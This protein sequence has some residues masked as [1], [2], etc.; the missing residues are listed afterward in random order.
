MIV[1]AGCAGLAAAAELRRAGVEDVSVLEARPR[2]GGRIHTI[3]G[4][5]LALPVELGA[6]LV[7]GAPD[8]TLRI[9]DAAGLLAIQLAGEH[10]LAEHGRVAPADGYLDDVAAVMRRLDPDVSPDRS[11][12][13]ALGAPPL[14]ELPGA[15]RLAALRY[16]EGFH[17]AEPDRMSARALAEAE[18][19]G[20]AGGESAARILDGYD[21]VPGW[22][23]AQAAGVRLRLGTVVRRV[24]WRRGAVTARGVDRWSGDVAVEAPVAIVTVPVGVLAAGAG[25]E[26]AIVFDPPLPEA[27]RRALAHQAMGAVVKLVFRFARAFWAERLEAM[28]YLHLPDGPF[29]VWWSTYPV[30]APLLVAWSGGPGAAALASQADGELERLALRDLATHLGMPVDS[31]AG[32]VEA[33]WHHDWTRDPYAR[34]AYSYV[35][36]GGAGAAE[37]LARPIE[38][39]LFLAGEALAPGGRN[40]TVD[41]AIASGRRAARRALAAL[42]RR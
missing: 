41:G 6:E 2:I 3:R 14:S 37:A 33:V 18:A 23:A 19:G 13:E 12:A 8:E 35:R 15:A 27:H 26:G 29:Q 31:L 7:H 30:R 39:T 36:V 25:E 40:G 32:E 5:G 17:A 34:G 16:V 4:T 21:R 1:G 42:G 38:G 11:V 10:Y 20:I 24:E 28:S 22:L 9:V